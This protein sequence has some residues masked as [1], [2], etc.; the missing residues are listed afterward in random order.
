MCRLYLIVAL[1]FGKWQVYISHIILSD[2]FMEMKMMTRQN[3]KGYSF[4]ISETNV[5]E[6]L[7]MFRL[8]DIS[9]QYHCIWRARILLPRA[10]HCLAHIL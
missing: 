8:L 9:I 10:V 4:I 6:N 5:K 2:T 7:I 3:G 1:K